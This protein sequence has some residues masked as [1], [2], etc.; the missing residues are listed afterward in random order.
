[1]TWK[2]DTGSS[3]DRTAGDTHENQS[4]STECDNE[5]SIINRGN[6]KDATP[7]NSASDASVN[8]VILPK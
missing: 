7:L 6:P 1:M 4:L 8:N 5:N 3:M 2:C